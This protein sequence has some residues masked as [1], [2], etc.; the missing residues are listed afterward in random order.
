MLLMSRR[1]TCAACLSRTALPER[2]AGHDGQPPFSIAVS[3][4]AR[5][6]LETDFGETRTAIGRP[7]IHDL[8]SLWL[9]EVE[10]VL[11]I[12]WQSAVPIVEEADARAIA[13]RAF[14]GFPP[15][16]VVAARRSIDESSVGLVI[17][18]V[19]FDWNWW[20]AVRLEGL[21]E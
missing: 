7:S 11:R 4:V 10:S 1:T 21:Q 3:A 19:T 16:S 15:A 5:R 20:E 14:L 9:P 13:V 2:Q 17:I 8:D 12:G 18:G 6:S